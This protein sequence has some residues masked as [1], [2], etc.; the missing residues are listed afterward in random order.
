MDKNIRMFNV[1][2]NHF[3]SISSSNYHKDC[4]AIGCLFIFTYP[5]DHSECRLP[6]RYK[7]VQTF[8]CGER[9]QIWP[10][11]NFAYI[12]SDREINLKIEYIPSIIA[13]PISKDINECGLFLVIWDLKKFLPKI[14][15]HSK[16]G[17]SPT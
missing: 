7:K 2:Q 8:R 17:Y 5:K 16:R 13:A 3:T 15:V 14:N 9:R 1:I 11:S 12:P 4:E 6:L 10:S